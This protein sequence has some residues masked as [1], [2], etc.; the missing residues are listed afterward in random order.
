[1]AGRTRGRGRMRRVLAG[2]CRRKSM[3]SVTSSSRS[4]RVRPRGA[5]YRVEM[6]RS[7]TAAGLRVVLSQGQR[8]VGGRGRVDMARCVERRWNGMTNRTC[9]DLADAI[10][11]GVVKVPGVS[12]NAAIRSV[13]RTVE[14]DRRCAQRT[15]SVTRRAGHLV[16]L[17]A[18]IDV[19]GRIRA[20]VTCRARRGHGYAC[21]TRVRFGRI[22]VA[23]IAR[24][25]WIRR[26]L[27]GAC[28][29]EV[30]IRLRAALGF[31][32]PRGESIVMRRQT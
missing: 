2:E 10:R 12:S 4:A 30:T 23:K 29:F 11:E 13:R 31:H 20:R 14:G 5:R 15:L 28:F 25:R 17:D 26:R 22:A 32:V 7:G 6:T 19:R 9:D 1:M 16:C 21:I 24:R 8:Y 18:T 27:P 3:T